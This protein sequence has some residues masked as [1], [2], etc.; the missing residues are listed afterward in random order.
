MNTALTFPHSCQT[1]WEPDV[2]LPSLP[3]NVQISW[4]GLLMKYA[5]PALLSPMTA[6]VLTFKWTRSVPVI[7]SQ[8]NL[9][10]WYRW[11]SHHE[12]MQIGCFEYTKSFT[13]PVSSTQFWKTQTVVFDS[14][15]FVYLCQFSYACTRVLQFTPSFSSTISLYLRNDASYSYSY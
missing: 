5:L 13:C 7:N 10:T 2:I 8:R 14:D 9:S 15:L 12:R 4:S 11:Y 3:R 6:V 1:N